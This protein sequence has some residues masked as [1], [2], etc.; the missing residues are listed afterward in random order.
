MSEG[1]RYPVF[2]R[3]PSFTPQFSEPFRPPFRRRA[4]K[5]PPFVGISAGIPRNTQ[6]ANLIYFVNKFG[7]L[8]SAYRGQGRP[9]RALPV[10]D[11][12]PIPGA[13]FGTL[14]SR[15]MTVSLASESSY[16]F[17]KL[18]GRSLPYPLVELLAFDNYLALIA[19]F[20]PP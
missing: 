2:P 9:A 12:S 10:F 11:L 3:L 15:H 1:E 6:K 20:L 7:L 5:R 13:G 19:H 8:A 17:G 18:L 14:S 16:S 4:Q